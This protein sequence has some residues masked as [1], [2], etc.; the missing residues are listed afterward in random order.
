[1]K[2]I[3]NKWF[4]AL[5]V[6][7]IIVSIG[8]PFLNKYYLRPKRWKQEFLYN[9]LSKYSGK[10]DSVRVSGFCDCVFDHLILT[11]KDISHFPQ[12]GIYTLDDKREI[13]KCTAKYLI[14]DS[15]E[16]QYFLKNVDTVLTRIK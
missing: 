7:T 4:L 3:K 8:Y 14:N 6:L 11:Y 16:K 12:N 1:M 10:I 5:A 13:I 9:T 15:I 2:D